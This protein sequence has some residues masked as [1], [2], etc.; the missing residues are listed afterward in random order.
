MKRNMADKILGLGNDII[1][2]ERIRSSLNKHRDHF[3][4]KLFTA[5]E[6]A[7]CSSH[8]DP[9]LSLAGRFAAKEAI[10][11]ALGCGFG[12][13]LSWLDLE[14]LNNDLGMPIVTCSESLDTRFNSPHFLISISHCK[15]YATAVAIWLKKTP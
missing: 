3:L 7:Y 1:E 10:A 11:K 13:D 14:I 4:N 6:Q 8:Q 12:K 9:A 5:K 15:E 2:I